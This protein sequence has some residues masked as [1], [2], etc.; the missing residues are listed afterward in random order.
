VKP[1][2]QDKISRGIRAA[3]IISDIGPRLKQIED[4]YLA[5]LLEAA[6]KDEPTDKK[7]YRLLALSDLGIALQTDVD[8]GRRASQ[9]LHAE[10]LQAEHRINDG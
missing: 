2:T 3:Q 7:V 5:E 6:R 1:T 8:T 4:Q 9:K 10:T